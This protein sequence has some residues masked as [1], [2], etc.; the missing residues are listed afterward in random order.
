VTK[1]TSEEIFAHKR[2]VFLAEQ[3]YRYR[4]EEWSIDDIN[5]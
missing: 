3:G 2:Q 1:E 4:I 5:A